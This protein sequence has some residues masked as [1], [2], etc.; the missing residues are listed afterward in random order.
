MI[1]IQTS[2]KYVLL[3]TNNSF[4]TKLNEILFLAFSQTPVESFPYS[5]TFNEGA[6]TQLWPFHSVSGQKENLF[7]KV[8]F[9]LSCKPYT[10]TPVTLL[11]LL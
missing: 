11:L 9:Y 4:Y 7:Q 1:H 10:C 3:K 8:S 2:D 5:N 6:K